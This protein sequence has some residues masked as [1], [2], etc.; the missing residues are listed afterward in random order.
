MLWGASDEKLSVASCLPAVIMMIEF[1]QLLIH[2]SGI[3]VKGILQST[4]EDSSDLT[5]K[6]GELN[7]FLCE[8]QRG[9]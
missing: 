4:V 9:R 8:S 5:M 1:S 2:P 3:A 7:C 6:A